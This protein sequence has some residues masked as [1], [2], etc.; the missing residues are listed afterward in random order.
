MARASACGGTVRVLVM[1]L[2]VFDLNW[3]VDCGF[4][5]RYNNVITGFDDFYKIGNSSHKSF[6]I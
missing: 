3:G 2:Y 4:L 1:E 5:L 6:L